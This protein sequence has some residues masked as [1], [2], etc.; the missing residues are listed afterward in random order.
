MPEKSWDLDRILPHIA[1]HLPVAAL[2]GIEVIA[3]EAERSRVRL[4]GNAHIWRPG[5]LIAG[6][7]LFAMADVA[8]YAL[9]LAL[10]Q[11]DVA[12][13]S[14]LVMNFLRPALAP[15]LIAEAVPLRAGRSLLHLAV[16]AGWLFNCWV[17]YGCAGTF[18]R[19]HDAIWRAFSTPGSAHLPQI[20]AGDD[21]FRC[22][23]L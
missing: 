5:G 6:P 13:T 3:A 10:K 8:T 4:I 9:T 23:T 20:S 11:E 15:P 2:F 12:V 7:V 19:Y 16:F 18:C 21:G 22:G 14:S 17:R 1:A